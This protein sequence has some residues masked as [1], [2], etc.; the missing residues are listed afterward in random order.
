MA[1]DLEIGGAGEEHTGEVSGGGAAGVPHE[2]GVGAVVAVAIAVL[3]D[4]LGAVGKVVGEEVPELVG[5]QG[6]GKEPLVEFPIGGMVYVVELVLAGVGEDDDAPRSDQGLVLEH[7]VSVLK[8]LVGDQEGIDEGVVCVA[9]LAGHAIQPDIALPINIQDLEGA[10]GVEGVVVDVRGVA[11]ENGGDLGGLGC[12]DYRLDA[13]D[14]SAFLGQV[15]FNNLALLPD[16]LVEGGYLGVHYGLAGGEGEGPVVV[17]D[18][19]E[20]AKADGDGFPASA[21]GD[22]RDI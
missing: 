4:E 2:E 7:A 3:V 1:G 8:P 14:A 6:H 21:E 5:I 19:P 11:C 18:A 15:I 16:E 20:G 17:P 10:E 9:C 22:M 13:E 12:G